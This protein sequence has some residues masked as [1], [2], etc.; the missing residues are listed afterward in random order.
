VEINRSAKGAATQQD[1]NL[2]KEDYEEQRLC[3]RALD[4]AIKNRILSIKKAYLWVDDTHNLDYFNKVG[5][6]IFGKPV[7][8]DL[9]VYNKS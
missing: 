8:Q 1:V 2:D 6:G 3:F 4:Y 7:A 5:F 9:I